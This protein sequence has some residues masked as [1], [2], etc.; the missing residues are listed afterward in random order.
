MAGSHVGHDCSIG[1]HVTLANSAMLGGHVSLGDYAFLG[2]HVAVH[3]FVR[4]GQGAMVAGMSA[5]RADLIPWGFAQ[6]PVAKLVGINLVGLRRRGYAKADIHRLRQAYREL[7]AGHG[8]FRDR[9]A[10]VEE[11]YPGDPLIGSILAFI[12]GGTRPLITE[13]ARIGKDTGEDA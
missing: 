4:V 8:L 13:T 7:F 5:L 12:R 6:G 10:R 3:Q 11:T 9:L 2:G 1:N